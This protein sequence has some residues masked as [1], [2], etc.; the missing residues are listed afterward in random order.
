MKSTSFQLSSSLPGP[1]HAGHSCETD[2]VVNDVIDLAVRQALCF[3]LPHVRR[4]RI[5]ILPDLRFPAS[6]IA[7]ARGAMVGEM[8]ARL[9][10]NF[11]CRRKRILSIAFGRGDGKFAYCSCDESL[12]RRWVVPRAES[13]ADS[14]PSTADGRSQ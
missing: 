5:K 13:A 11:N 9:V 10:E 4:L 12:D 6:I 3:G 8:G 2:S 14:R 1:P 7:V